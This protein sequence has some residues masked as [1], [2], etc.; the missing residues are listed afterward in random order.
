MG[1]GTRT[2]SAM[3]TLVIGVVLSCALA[4]F[5]YFRTDLSTAFATFAGLIGTTI[6]LQ[7]ESLRRERQEREQA[8][9]DQRLI[10][11]METAPWMPELLDRTLSAYSAV[12]QNYGST[13]AVELSRKA[14][15]NCQVQL[16]DLARGLYITQDTEE[17]PNSPFYRLTERLH[18]SLLTT[19]AGA[20]IEWWLDATRTRTYWRLNQEALK[21]GVTI[22]RIFMYRTWSNALDAL[23][24]AQHAH[25]VQVLRV[26]ESELPSALRLN[27]T[28]WD[29]QT[30]LEA[31][32]NSAAEWTGNVFNFT[33]QDVTLLLQQIKL[34]EA[35]A[36]PWP[37]SSGP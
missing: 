8:T 25:G 18:T 4:V 15:E 30:G 16:E 13:M 33:A 5:F 1:R 19:S 31:K 37:I 34:I 21:R 20:D 24:T 3:L 35:R 6:T 10:A 36:E 7:V 2:R 23:A 11:Q 12:V 22:K 32:Y 27:L 14:L 17:S 26:N 9:R 28:V 29:G